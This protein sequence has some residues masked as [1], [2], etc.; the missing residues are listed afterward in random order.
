MIVAETPVLGIAGFSG[1]GKTTLLQKL[2]PALKQHGLSVGLIK[3][4]HHNFDIDKPGK[5]SYVLRKAGASPVMLVSSRRRAMITEFLQ[6]R[7]P[8]LQEELDHFDCTGLDLVLVEG[9]KREAFP[10]IELHRPQTGHPN[11]FPE[12]P[13]IIALATDMRPSQPVSVPVLDLNRPENICRFILED[14][15]GR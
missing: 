2:I 5:D 6:E 8:V 10:K 7:E 4:G 3:H 9:F 12:D 14:F 11:L 1:S 13:S 15:L